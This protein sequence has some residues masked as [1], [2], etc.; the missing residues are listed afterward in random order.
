MN[1]PAPVENPRPADGAMSLSMLGWALN[2]EASI[3][4][5]VRRAE[6]FLRALC[7]D[8]ELVLVDDGSTDRTPA[9]LQKLQQGRPW[10]KVFRNERNRGSGYNTKRAI[11]LA[12]KKYL[13]W[14]MVDWSY[15]LS[16]LPEAVPFLNRVDV[17]Q[18]VRAGRVGRVWNRSDTTYKGLISW[19]NYT[20]VRRLFAM[21]V[22]DFQNVTIYPSRLIQAMTIESESA[23]TN[24]ECLIKTWWSGASVLEFPVAFLPRTRG[25]AK[26]TRIPVVLRSI[27][28][29]LKWWMKWRV[30][31]GQPRSNPGPVF[32]WDD[33]IRREGLPGERPAHHT[34]KDRIQS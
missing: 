23:F 2:E 17:L 24:P 11:S 25:L 34:P 26:G 4:E 16:Y 28:D 33:W 15:D 21:P 8:F 27:R 1:S 14:Q 19:V 5:Y 32:Y 20:L 30:L 13:F 31:E 6:E 3:E 22:H 12:T 9:I 29:I 10:L 7:S 18:G